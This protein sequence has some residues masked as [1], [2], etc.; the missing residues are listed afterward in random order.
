MSFG[1]KLNFMLHWLWKRLLQTTKSLCLYFIACSKF[2]PLM[3]H[4]NWRFQCLF[5]RILQ[6]I[7]FIIQVLGNDIPI[8]HASTYNIKLRLDFKC[9]AKW[10][11][12]KKWYRKQVLYFICEIFE[13]KETQIHE[14]IYYGWW[15]QISKSTW[16]MHMFQPW[17]FNLFMP[18]KSWF[19]I[20]STH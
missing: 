9:N 16:P 18:K 19:N 7:M 10:Y 8:G 20:I 12:V 13:W 15:F 11:K 2:H 14:G 4:W 6:M 5:W 17:H 3:L 1:P